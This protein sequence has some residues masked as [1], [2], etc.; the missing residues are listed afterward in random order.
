MTA[1]CMTATPAGPL[2]VLVERDSDHPV[3][4]DPDASVLAH[5]AQELG[6]DQHLGSANSRVVSRTQYGCRCRALLLRHLAA[7]DLNEVNGR[8]ALRALLAG[9]SLRDSGDG[10]RDC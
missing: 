4:K 8:H 10:G 6:R 5:D 7:V 9:G 2:P 3:Q 1:V